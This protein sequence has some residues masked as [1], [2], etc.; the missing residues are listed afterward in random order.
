MLLSFL[1]F[2]IFPFE[3]SKRYVQRL[4]S[5]TYSNG[6]HRDA[7]LVLRVGVGLPEAVELSVFDLGF[8]RNRFSLRRK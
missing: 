6:I 8:F 7:F 4:V 5:E 2:G 1:G 3:V